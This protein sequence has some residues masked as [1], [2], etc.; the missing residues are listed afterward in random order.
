MGADGE[1]Y[2]LQA[3][4]LADERLAEPPPDFSAALSA[5]HA[6]ARNHPALSAAASLTQGQSRALRQALAFAGLAGLLW[7]DLLLLAV[8]GLALCFFV[9]ALAYRLYVCLVATVMPRKAAVANAPSR[10][11]LPVYTLLIALKDETAT[12]PQLAASL[13]ALN[14]PHHLLD[15]KLLIEAGD[16]ATR[17]AL[18]AEYWPG[19]AELITVPPGEPRTKPRAL[20]YGLARARG[21]FIVVYD[22]ED[23]PHPDQLNEAVNTFRQ[24]SRALACVQ[25]PLVGQGGRGWLA[26]QWALEYAVQ[27]GCL[28][29]GL[30]ALGLPIALGGTSNHFRRSWLEAVGAWDPW[31]VTEDADLGLRLAR[32]GLEVRMIDTPTL[33][34]PPEKAGVWLAQRSRWLKGYLQTW[35]V[36]MRRPRRAISELGLGGFLSIQLTLGAALL[37]ALVHGPWA[38]WLITSLA[39]PSLAPWPIFLALAAMSY[40]AGIL[41]A[42]TAPGKRGLGRLLLAL[43]QPFYWPLQT[44]AMARA[45]YGLLR[46][47]HY[48]AKTPHELAK[49]NLPEPPADH[50]E[51]ET[52]YFRSHL[53]AAAAPQ[54]SDAA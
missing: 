5:A 33:E 21:E 48:W 30:A 8:T 44:L 45:I 3:F 34:A 35:L 11:G 36:I 52:F 12:I 46:R 18:L 32:L 50:S 51:T 28:M 47:P 27:F 37:S 23:R 7:I 10:H 4:R 20:N 6:L 24:G 39:I 13:R 9:T 43:T 54:R 53:A 31:N 2:T 29:P 40:I 15:V 49:A 14:Y 19:R 25:A 26:S 16:R 1:G 42:L 22:A 41:L 38:F 17:K